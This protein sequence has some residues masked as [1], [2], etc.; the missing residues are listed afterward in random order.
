MDFPWKTIAALGLASALA[1]CGPE[2]EWLVER[3]DGQPV[4][5]ERPVVTFDKGR[6]SAGAGCNGSGGAYRVGPGDA[7]AVRDLNSTLVACIGAAG[8]RSMQLEHQIGLRLARVRTFTRE[9]GR[10]RLLSDRGDLSLVPRPRPARSIE[11]DWRICQVSP[12][13]RAI[14]E[15]LRVVRFHDG[16]VEER[17]GCR[18]V[19]SLGGPALHMRFE[20]TPACRA[21]IASAREAMSRRRSFG[22]DLP[23]PDQAILAAVQPR[24]A[25]FTHGGP[26]L[27]GD[28][29]EE[30]RLC[31][32][33][34]ADLVP[35]EAWTVEGRWVVVSGAD[36]RTHALSFENGV[37][38]ESGGCRGR[39][40]VSGD[41]L[42]LSF[43]AL[44]S[45]APARSVRGGTG[46]WRAA[47]P[48]LAPTARLR[49]SR[50]DNLELKTASGEWL[51]LRRPTAP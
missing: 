14:S 33:E 29:G 8:E 15:P 9:G 50:F 40:R 34:A 6:V 30:I 5:G 21:A 42:E 7:L 19:Y 46:V 31:R 24:R 1:G 26:V 47:L 44:A 35:R 37:V 23:R 20:R 48:G 49:F 36:D 17:A 28:R 3:I 41:Q 25:V 12:A 45:C 32:A 2:G 18:G 22:E 10:L 11:G 4:A 16:L 43:P 13:T 38:S 51:Y 27:Q 39:Y